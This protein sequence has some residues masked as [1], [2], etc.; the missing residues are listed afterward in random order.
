MFL[1]AISNFRVHRIRVVLTITA[2]ALSMSLVVAVTS[3]YSSVQAAAQKGLAGFLGTTDAQLTRRHERGGTFS[4]SVINALR[5]DPEVAGALGRLELTTGLISS[6]GSITASYVEVIGVQRPEDRGVEPMRLHEGKWF[7]SSDTFEAVID[8][9]ALERLQAKLG[10]E[11][12]LPS[13]ER[14]LKLKIVGVVHKPGLLA[15]MKQSIYVPLHTLQNFMLPDNPHQVTRVLIDFKPGADEIAFA[16]RWEN[17]PAEYGTD[18]RMKVSNQSREQMDQNLEGIQ[19]MSYLGGSIAMVAATFI[20]FSAL[21][22]GVAERQRT[23]AMLRAIGA[24]KFQLGQLVL[25]EG[26]VLAVAGILIGIPLGI[27]WIHILAWFYAEWFTAGAVVS[28]TGVT[29]G[30]IGS[31]LTSLMATLMPAWGAMRASPLEAMAHVGQPGKR[32]NLL[33]SFFAGL[34]LLCVDPLISFTNLSREVRFYGHFSVGIAA[35]MFGAFLLSPLLVDGLNRFVGPVIAAMFGVRYELLKQQLASAIWRS[36]GAAAALMVGLAILVVTQTMGTSFI[37]GWKLPD[38]FP[39]MFIFSTLGLDPNEQKV[40]AATPEFRE[41]EFLP[42]SMAAPELGFFGL[43]GAAVM[44]SATM[45]FGVDPE[46]AFKMMDL[47]FRDGDPATAQRLLKQG[48]HIIVSQ[49]FRQIKG[50]GVGDKLELKTNKGKMD[51]TIAGVVWS[52]GIDVIRSMQD[53]GTQF[54]QRTAA[55]IF[56]S[57]EDARTYFGADRVHLFAANVKPAVDKDHLIAG[58][59]VNLRGKGLD[60]GDVR[61]I[62]AAIQ[63]MLVFLLNLVS[64]ISYAAMGIAWFGVMN[65]IMASIRTRRWQLG[66]LRSIGVT[67]DQL[68]RLVLA[69]AFLLAIAGIVLGLLAGGLLSID[70][71]EL[72]GAI[73]GYKPP[74]VIP[75]TAVGIGILSVIV[76]SMAASLWPAIYVARS[77][78][79]ALLQA[80]RSAV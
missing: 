55:S 71:H 39:D 8:Q 18:L 31:L 76:V 15:N 10:D 51:F 69:E 61:H 33:L 74:L 26:M 56:G 34:L 44:P 25:I 37:Q 16:S 53:L 70:A 50:L 73:I 36:A 21:S 23:M 6:T 20:I 57:M 62:K 78:P 48:K 43:A 47:D 29:Y 40:L 38:R 3:G 52:P 11:F 12:M 80:G 27:V 22:M 75:W 58:I 79:L 49:E 54:D 35:V 32:S 14:R 28:T 68:L 60:A 2:I 72:W 7:D 77:E 46:I 1:L 66:I 42:I 4:D 9:V 13:L 5:A 59:R 67:R 17:V 45:F 41:G 24:L 19:A 30:A 64:L 63:R 65:T